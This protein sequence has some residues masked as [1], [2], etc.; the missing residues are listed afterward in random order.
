MELPPAT[1]KGTG[2]PLCASVVRMNSDCF[3]SDWWSSEYTQVIT[4]PVRPRIER[5]VAPRYCPKEVTETDVKN[6]FNWHS[7]I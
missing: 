7:R 6:K 3:R 1:R 5:P 4:G 2:T